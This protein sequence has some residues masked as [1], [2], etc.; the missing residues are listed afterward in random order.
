MKGGSARRQIPAAA[1]LSVLG[2][3]AL[4]WFAAA[5]AQE[6]QP[7]VNY[8]Y[9]VIPQQPV[10]TAGRIE[11]I[12]FF[13]YGCP[14]CY[15][16][17]PPLEQWLVRKPADVELRRI[18][19][20][21][22]ESWIPHARVFYTLQNLGELTRLHHA[23][24]RALHVDRENLGSAETSAA[25]AA[26][27]GIDP[28]RWMSIYSSAEV[29]QQ[30]RDAIASTRSYAVQGTPSLVVDGRYITSTGMSETIAG[31][32]DILDDLIRI[33]RAERAAR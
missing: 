26:R 14:Y 7:R 16:L 4:G 24:Y 5:A 29:E 6:R 10:A 9:R 1:F 33:A 12:E 28:A 22:R 15:Q 30:V 19:A 11:V 20:V 31:V 2:L 25:W 27:N 18:P 17:Q 32:V 21:F 8:E 13:W 3:L 23:V